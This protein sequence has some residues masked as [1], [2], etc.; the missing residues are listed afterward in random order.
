MAENKDKLGSDSLEKP[1]PEFIDSKAYRA[2]IELESSSSEK[3]EPEVIGPPPQIVT[4]MKP[5]KHKKIDRRAIILIS[6]TISFI[7]VFI[8]ARLFGSSIEFSILYGL[9][10]AVAGGLIA[11]I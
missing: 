8:V 9:I 4:R 10:G 7:G 5:A 2:K 6:G 3:P 1:E 11:S